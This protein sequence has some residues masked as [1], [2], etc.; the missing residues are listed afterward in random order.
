MCV[1]VCLLRCLANDISAGGSRLSLLRYEQVQ[2]ANLTLMIL[3]LAI[4][5]LHIPAPPPLRCQNAGEDE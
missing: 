1:C 4:W 3:L 2:R 5:V